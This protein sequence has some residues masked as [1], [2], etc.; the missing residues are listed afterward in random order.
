MVDRDVEEALDLLRVQVD[1]QHA[2]GSGGGEHVGDQ[3]GGDGNAGL[4]LAVLPGVAEVG[5]HGGDAGGA[6]AAGGVDHDEQLH[7]IVVGTVAGGLDQKRVGAAD[8]LF[9]L[10][11][12]L[13]VGE[14]G[15]MHLAQVDA[16]IVGDLL[17]KLRMRGTGVDANVFS[18]FHFGRMPHL[19]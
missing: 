14:V 3:L 9:E 17:R 6:R 5:E 11:E 7:Q 2:V 19:F 15:D 10:D 16:Q 8:V 13:A 1:R 4:V 12:Y 18:L